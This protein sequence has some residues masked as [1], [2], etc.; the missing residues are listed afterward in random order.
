[1]EYFVTSD[2][3]KIYYKIKGEGKTIIFIHGF[4]EDYNSFRIQ[5]NVLSESYKTIVYDL[6]GHGISERVDYGLNLERFA[7][8]LKELIHRLELKNVTLVGW[9]MGG[10]VIFEYIRQFGTDNIYKICLVDIGPKSLNDNEWDKGLLHGKYKIED[11]TKDLVLIDK[12]WMDFAE[13]F[14]KLMSPS[15]DIKQFNIALEKMGRNSP[16]VMYYMWKSIGEKDYRDVLEKIDV[17]T[18]ILVGGKSTF[19][20]IETGEYL[21]DNIHNSKLVVF[22]DCTHL[23]VLENPIK[24]NRVLKEFI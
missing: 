7:L 18:L 24:F 21:R 12:N 6:R 20:S 19:Y 4:S 9:S 14:I 10:S 16:H 8:D 1:M 17:P 5:Q 23:L 15:F 11:Y 2:H 22:E 3:I 13:K